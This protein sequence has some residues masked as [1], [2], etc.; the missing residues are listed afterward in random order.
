MGPLRFELRTSAMSRR[1]HNRLDHEPS[2]L[3]FKS[4]KCLSEINLKKFIIHQP[5]FEPGFE[6]WQRPVM[7][8][9]LLMFFVFLVPRPGFEP[10]TTASSGQRSP[11]EL[12][13][14]AGRIYQPSLVDIF[15]FPFQ[16][17][18]RKI[19]M[20]P[21]RFEL[22]TSAMSRRRHNRLDHE[23]NSLSFPF[24]AS[25]CNSIVHIIIYISFGWSECSL[26][27]FALKR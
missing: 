27:E 5:G 25:K 22:R 18:L 15:I 20:G 12:P 9:T 14:Q 23:P 19:L 10:G 11:T 13:G 24:F 17:N 1:R 3:S 21:L 6:R 16:K 7:T 26:F 4:G 2:S 8:A